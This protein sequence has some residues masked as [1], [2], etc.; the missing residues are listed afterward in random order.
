MSDHLEDHLPPGQVGNIQVRWSLVLGPK[1]EI[2]LDYGN[3][4]PFNW[5]AQ[6]TRPQPV[7]SFVLDFDSVTANGS[8]T[9][10]LRPEIEDD[11]DEGAEA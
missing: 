5:T 9:P 1:Q 3:V 11:D 2:R 10:V 6:E 7:E 4:W 8:F